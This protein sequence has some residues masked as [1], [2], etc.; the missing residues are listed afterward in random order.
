MRLLCGAT[1][2]ATLAFAATAVAA[3]KPP[4]FVTVKLAGANGSTEPRMA[5]G[6]DNARYVVTNASGKGEV[7]YASHDGGLS[8]APVEGSPPQTSATID[9]DIVTMPTGR[10]LSSELDD[11][12]LN[13]PTG[14]SDDGGK[15]WTQSLGSN[16]LAD[17]DRQWFAVG[18]KP[19]GAA[20]PPVYLLYHNF[21]S[22]IPQHNMWVATSSDG[23]ATFGLPVPT[24]Q[25][26]SDAY[27]DLQC[28]DSGGPSS[29]TVN[30]KTGHIY[31]VFTT[32][33]A[34]DP[35]TGSVDTGGCGASVFGPLE[36]NIVNAT[37]VWVAD[38]A[39]GLPGSWHDSL[40]VDDNPTQQVVSQQLAYGALD[41][42]GNFYVAYPESPKPY[43]DLTGSGVKLTWQEPLPNGQLDSRWSKPVTLVPYD[44]APGST[45]AEPK[46]QNGSDLVHIVAGDP[47]K[48]AVAYFKAETVPGAKAPVWY[49]HI[50]QSFDARSQTPHV[51]DYKVPG[52]DGAPIPTYQWTASQMMGICS[53]TPVVQGVENGL[54]CSRSTD[55]WAI[56]LDKSCRVMAA[57]PARGSTSGGGTAQA[58]ATIPN[59]DNGTFVT[60]QQGGPTLCGAGGPG[61]SLALP[62]QSTS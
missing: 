45:A 18:P 62:F 12:G 33:A 13:F 60:T 25:P 57:W 29:I 41:N 58:G 23:G 43:P 38:S 17:Q 48:I 37:R 6:K 49:T 32:R 55:V 28:S 3:P 19:A 15:T 51:R 9:T 54:D 14:Y 26:G 22:G 56:S 50:L 42:K 61:G 5:V 27:Q 31:V 11:A 4:Q 16:Q 39:T 46:Y 7:V 35:V 59:H 1:L 10:I 44:T 8:F 52:P 47:G 40:A 30:P 36:F 2:A 34:P 21:A 53:S 24:A 20:Q